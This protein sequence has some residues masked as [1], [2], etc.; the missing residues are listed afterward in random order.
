MLSRT[1]ST[2]L[3]AGRKA[4]HGVGGPRGPNHSLLSAACPAAGGWQEQP[5]QQQPRRRCHL[6]F[7]RLKGREPALFVRDFEGQR[8]TASTSSASA[9]VSSTSLSRLIVGVLRIL[10]ALRK[11]LHGSPLVLRR[12]RPRCLLVAFVVSAC[13]P[14]CPRPAPHF[15]M[16]A[17]SQRHGF[18]ESSATSPP[19]VRPAGRH[20]H[21]RRLKQLLLLV[22]LGALLL[23]SIGS[24]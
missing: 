6:G 2:D 1:L 3:S 20:G 13:S 15:G 21:E 18:G 23:R 17:K 14:V 7:G 8:P 19:A 10:D 11:R 9:L 24:A 22:A 4:L 16:L 12:K 5:H